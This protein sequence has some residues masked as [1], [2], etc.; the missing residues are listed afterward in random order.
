LL[1]DMSLHRYSHDFSNA[2]KIKLTVGISMLN[3]HH[4][5]A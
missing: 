1:I 2:N 3:W 4:K 5:T